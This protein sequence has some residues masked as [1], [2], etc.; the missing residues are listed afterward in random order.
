MK[1]FI[2]NLGDTVRVRL[3]TGEVVDARY[4]HHVYKGI[5]SVTVR[6]RSLDLNAEKHKPAL[7]DWFPYE[8]VRFVG[9]SCGL[10]TS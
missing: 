4:R 1:F 9:P 8:R 7:T 10:V 6:G 5:H 2:P 3:H